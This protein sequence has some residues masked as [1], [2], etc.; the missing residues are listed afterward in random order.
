[1]VRP[2]SEQTG[3]RDDARLDEEMR[4]HLDQ[5]IAK[6]VRQGLSPEAAR[7]AALVRF[8]GVD[9][10]KDSTRDE[11][12]GAWLRDLGRDVRYGARLLR[13][14]P[15]FA[16]LAI[17]TLGL[18]I[19]ASTALFSVVDGVLLRELPY[20]EPDRIV[21]LYQMNVDT[22]GTAPRRSGNVAEPNVIDWRARTRGFQAIAVMSQSGPVPVSGGREAVMARRTQVSNEFFT[23]MGVLPAGGRGFP[24][25]A[26]REGGV[27]V[28]IVSAVFRARAFGDTI[29]PG[30][31]VR[32]GDV[33]YAVAGEMPVGFDFPGGTELWTPRELDP[34]STA[35]TAHN[36][37]VVARLADGVDLDA[38][39]ADLS[40]VSRAM[41]T[42]Y[43]D[44]TWMVDA[45]GVPLLE[46]TVAGVR[47]ALQLLFGAA[48]VLF[49]IA[50]T[51]VTNL[52]LARDAARAHEVALQLAIGAG[53]WRIIRQR[54]AETL[55]LCLTGAAFGLLIAGMATRGLL[56]LDPGNVPRLTQVGLDW[57]AM[58]FACLAAIVATTLIGLVAAFR[59]ADRD[60][61]SV[62]ADAARSTTGGRSRERA[63]HALVVTQVALTLVLLVGTALLARSFS[64]LLSI[65]PGYR[66]EGA[67]VLDLAMPRMDRDQL[68]RQ[69]ALQQELMIRLS[70]LP[71]VTGVGLVNGLP[72]GGGSYPNGQYLEMTRADEFQSYDDVVALGPRVQE[73]AGQA[74][75]RVAGGDYFDVMGIPVLAGRA[76]APG[77]TAEAPHIAVVSQSF[78]EARWPGRDPI[79]RFVQ[80]GN[81]D[82]DIRGF[83][84]VGVVGDVRELSPET[85]PG[86]IFYVDYRQ[87]PR[88]AS[89]VS[90]VVGG[91]RTDVG[92][93]AQRILRELDPDLPLRSRTIEDAFDAALRGR[94]FNLML[95]TAFGAAALGL[96]VLGTY[97]L[98]SYL[99]T[100]RTREIGI[101]LALGAAP[102]AVVRLIAARGARLAAAGITIGLAAAVLMT[103]LIDGLL[104]A[105]SPTDP[106]SLA[107][108]AALTAA[109]VVA[110]S[111]LPAWRAARISPTE[112][113][114][115]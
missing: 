85:P 20:P 9:A 103:G 67:T 97:G 46:Q 47:P 80:F 45:A 51:N 52:L 108:V 59:S 26:L 88:Q 111:L 90:V 43:G 77:D 98:M 58:A 40:A 24:P 32:I 53:R 33:T 50:C 19:G 93:S 70:R 25:E 48:V 55:V 86:P 42:E 56:A 22:A 109:A 104:F 37:Q 74:A 113:L 112:T 68:P 44:T 34:P 114:R 63:R 18:G 102:S 65:D 12:R 105:I 28:A 16:A 2:D 81:M 39:A 54:L 57:Q 31:T 72:T 94:R 4:F 29:P 35:R 15:G 11:M 30:A 61:R 95:I 75:F 7:R 99:V 78:A 1:M 100:Q 91:G 23:V 66:T 62:L 89:N 17:L 60:L 92:G 110:A 101:R 73:R 27:P 3:R 107:V 76:F 5:Q 83:R 13:R 84:I 115:G 41:K 79:G 8:G 96:A 69:V 38:A 6:L 36:Y 49:V 87:R 106:A 82:G 10:M 14:T 64:Q 71:G 21:R